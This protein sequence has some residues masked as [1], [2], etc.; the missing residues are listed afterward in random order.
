MD[1]NESKT[2]DRGEFAKAMND[3]RITSDPKE[4]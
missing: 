4:V 1:D 3:Y 2:L